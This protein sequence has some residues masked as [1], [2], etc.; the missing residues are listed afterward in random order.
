[1]SWLILSWPIW[2]FHKWRWTDIGEALIKK[3][4]FGGRDFL[5]TSKMRFKKAVRKNSDKKS[6]MPMEN[7]LALFNKYL[8]NPTPKE[9]EMHN[10][11]E[12]S[13]RSRRGEKAIKKLARLAIGDLT[14]SDR[15]TGRPKQTDKKPLLW[16]FAQRISA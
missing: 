15:P 5:P 1:M 7:W 2:D 10:D 13:V 11:W 9:K 6:S 8:F 14:V 12:R 3:F 16:D 4:Q